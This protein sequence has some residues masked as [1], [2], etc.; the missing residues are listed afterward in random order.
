MPFA[1]KRPGTDRWARTALLVA[2]AII[3][4]PGDIG[5]L[6][7]NP[8][9]V[10]TVIGLAVVGAIVFTT[11]WRWP[12]A[13]AIVSLVLVAALI[14]DDLFD[15]TGVWGRVSLLA[16]LALAGTA[17][18]ALWVGCDRSMAASGAVLRQGPEHA[19]G[20]D[21]VKRIF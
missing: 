16:D 1:V 6:I 4:I 17:A 7:F 20:Q 8:H 11:A 12:R 9:R 19:A 13:L 3:L 21:T 14:A 10:A 15:G 5:D 18:A 2:W